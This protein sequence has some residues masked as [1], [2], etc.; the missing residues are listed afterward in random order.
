[1]NFFS[2]NISLFVC[3]TIP[4]HFSLRKSNPICHKLYKDLIQLNIFLFYPY[5]LDCREGHMKKNSLCVC[6]CVC[7]KVKGQKNTDVFRVQKS[8]KHCLRWVQRSKKHG[9]RWI[10]R[11]KKHQLLPGS[12]VK[13]T[14]SEMG[15]KV[16]KTSISS[17]FKSQKNMV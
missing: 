9:L 7:G 8:K 4:I 15:S 14:L 12:K 6:G 13:K 2:F 10:Q 3:L 16:K 1:M 11:S 17:R 5:S